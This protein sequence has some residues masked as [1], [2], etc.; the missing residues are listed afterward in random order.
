MPKATPAPAPTRLPNKRCLR[1]AIHGLHEYRGKFFPQLVRALM[2][3]A[4]LPENAVV[5]DPMCGSGTTLVEARL[6]GRRCFGIDMNPP[7]VFVSDV[8]CEALALRPSALVTST[9]RYATSCF[10]PAS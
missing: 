2:N 10:L 7:S 4:R 5:L 3:V 6:S 1:D 8:K 9:L